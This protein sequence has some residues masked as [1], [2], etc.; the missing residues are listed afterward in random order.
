MT[1]EKI[2]N[3]IETAL[4]LQHGQITAESSTKNTPGWDSIGHISILV[5]LDKLFD[6]KA[7]AVQELGT[8]S[9]VNSICEI[10]KNNSII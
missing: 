8:A 7:A 3:T 2:Y 10:L 6:G 5:A 1:L 4:E 9:S